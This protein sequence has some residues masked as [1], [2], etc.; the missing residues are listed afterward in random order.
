M[1]Y[2]YLFGLAV[3]AVVALGGQAVRAQTDCG[4]ARCAVQAAIDQEC[5]CTTALNHGRHVSCVA[6]VVNRLSRDNTDTD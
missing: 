1:R 2:G 3:G 6:H 5:P 4:S